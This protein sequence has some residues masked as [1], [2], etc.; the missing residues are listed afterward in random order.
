MVKFILE[1]QSLGNRLSRNLNDIS[2]V[3]LS[4]SRSLI[5]YGYSNFTVE[6]LEHYSIDREQFYM[7]LLKPDYNLARVFTQDLNI[8]RILK[9]L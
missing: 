6:I 9:I 4:I 1:V 5:A 7:N 3:H 8:I 2:T